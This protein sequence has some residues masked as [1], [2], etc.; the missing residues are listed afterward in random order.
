M[1]II[2]TTDYETDL[3]FYALCRYKELVSE[4]HKIA[5][6]PEKMKSVQELIERIGRTRKA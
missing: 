6:Y 4:H 1:P 2:K 5:G 3:I